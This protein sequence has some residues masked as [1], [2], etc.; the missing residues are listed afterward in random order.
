MKFF[1]DY[2]YYRVAQYFFKSDGTNAARAIFAISMFQTL[3]VMIVTELILHYYFTL[4]ETRKHIKIA[5]LFISII[6]L[7]LCLLNYKKYKKS[8]FTFR[9]HWIMESSS[10]RSLKG[11]FVILALFIPWLLFLL[12]AIYLPVK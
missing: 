8:F 5:G 1:F 6:F 4:S 9:E 10:T 3:I 2:I 12:L 11:F 7:I